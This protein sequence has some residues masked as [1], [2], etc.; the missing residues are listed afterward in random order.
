MAMT[1]QEQNIISDIM[2]MSD[3]ALDFQTRQQLLRARW[4][5][6]DVFNQVTDGELLEIGSFAHLTISE[7]ANAMGALDDISTALGD[8][9]TG[10]AV[11]LIKMKG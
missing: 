6:N 11:D 10:A 8:Y 3:E 5:Q 1:A 9:S 7:V 2:S 4:D